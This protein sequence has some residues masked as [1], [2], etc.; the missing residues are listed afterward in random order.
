MMNLVYTVVSAIKKKMNMLFKKNFQRDV[1][2]KQKEKG[3][4]FTVIN[5]PLKLGRFVVKLVLKVQ[6][7]EVQLLVG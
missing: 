1:M 2:R 7:V 6:P 4:V 5:S 3:H